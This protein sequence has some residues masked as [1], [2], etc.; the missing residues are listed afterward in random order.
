LKR[1]QN[2]AGATLGQRRDDLPLEVSVLGKETLMNPCYDRRYRMLL[3]I[4]IVAGILIGS[5]AAAPTADNTTYLPFVV[6][7]GHLLRADQSVGGHSLTDAALIT[8]QF[9]ASLDPGRYPT[10]LPYQ[11]LNTSGDR[12]FTVV[13]NTYF[14][15][16]IA[17]VDDS[18]PILGDFPNSPDE[19]KLYFFDPAQV[20]AH[21][22]FIDVD[23]TRYAIGP[24]YLAGPVTTEPLPT[25]GGTH[26]MVLAAF[27]HP[28]PPGIHLV[29]MGA[30]FDG[31]AI[32]EAYGGPVEFVVTY[33]VIVTDA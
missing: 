8:A 15:I 2:A 12:T 1:F 21:D 29:S 16:P 22:S 18:P 13:S 26:Y 19:A 25:G 3:P 9:N 33:E 7:S 5:A 32:L 20:G 11:I 4:L 30:T 27:M 17:F 24:A 10:G 14:Y 28:L 6:G 31:A 23:G